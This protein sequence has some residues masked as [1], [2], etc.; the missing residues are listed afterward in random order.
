[1][2]IKEMAWR[3]RWCRGNRRETGVI[4]PTLVFGLFYMFELV[5]LYNAMVLYWFFILLLLLLSTRM[6]LYAHKHIVNIAK[7]RVI[8]LKK[9]M[10]DHILMILSIAKNTLFVLLILFLCNVL[11]LLIHKSEIK[12]PFF[13][14][15][16]KNVCFVKI[17]RWPFSPD[18]R[19]KHDKVF[20]FFFFFFFFIFFF[21][22]F[23]FLFFFF[24]FF[25][26]F[27][28]FF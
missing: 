15:H 9:N 14:F 4:L 5:K 6:Q 25:F 28:F 19:R 22:F 20:F 7:E 21:F 17:N 23:F 11:T 3:D 10:S 18:S 24:L 13:L 2:R 8:I 1:M 16:G 26:I 12:T 27:F